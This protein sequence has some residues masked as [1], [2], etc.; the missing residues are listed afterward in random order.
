MKK[1]FFL[2]LISLNLYACKKEQSLSFKIHG[3]IQD[4]S[5]HQPLENATVII[6]EKAIGSSNLSEIGRTTTDENGDYQVEFP[7]NRV[8][9]YLVTIQKD[10]YFESSHT[11]LF[12]ELDPKES[13]E[14]NF[15]TTAHSWVKI[16]LKN[17]DE[18]NS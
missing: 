10:R 5:L 7:R 18:V 12:S 11:V 17:V 15:S 8:E 16:V 9:N 14:Y 3:S 4:E 2:L 1:F 13:K 6:Y